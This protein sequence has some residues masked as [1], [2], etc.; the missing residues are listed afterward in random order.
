MRNPPTEP[1]R[2]HKLYP[3]GVS[4]WVFGADELR[5]KL[6]HWLGNR[7]KFCL[8]A[9][10]GMMNIGCNTRK[11]DSSSWGWQRQYLESGKDGSS[12]NYPRRV[13]TIV[14]GIEHWSRQGVAKSYPASKNIRPISCK[15]SILRVHSAMKQIIGG[16]VHPNYCSSGPPPVPSLSPA[17]M[18]HGGFPRS[19]LAP[20]VTLYYPRN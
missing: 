9:G 20:I 8:A 4:L 15:L 16:S 17:E 5:L 14:L 7:D 6:R 13:K 12:S 10:N 19:A 11:C 18:D 3:R 2:L 1:P